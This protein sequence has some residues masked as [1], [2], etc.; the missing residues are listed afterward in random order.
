MSVTAVRFAQSKYLATSS[1]DCEC[2]TAARHGRCYA[3]FHGVSCRSRGRLPPCRELLLGSSGP[4]SCSAR[5]AGGSAG[6]HGRDEQQRPPHLRIGLRKEDAD[7]TGGARHQ[8]RGGGGRPVDLRDV[9]A[10]LIVPPWP[11]GARQQR[12]RAVAGS[13]RPGGRVRSCWPPARG[14][15]NNLIRRHGDQLLDGMHFAADEDDVKK[16]NLCTVRRCRFEV[17]GVEAHRRTE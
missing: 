7:F 4:R 2:L 8:R 1:A 12:A 16:L 9:R 13:R 14:P 11:N 15:L 5:R 17:A 10:W 3:T 6:W